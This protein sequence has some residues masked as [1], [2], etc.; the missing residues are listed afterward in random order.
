MFAANFLNL[1]KFTMPDVKNDLLRDLNS[2]IR[3]Y[4]IPDAQIITIPDMGE[5]EEEEEQ[6]EGK[7]D[8]EE[9]EGS[10][11]LDDESES[12]G[13][14]ISPEASRAKHISPSQRNISVKPI[15][16]RTTSSSRQPK[17]KLFVKSK[18]LFSQV[19]KQAS[20]Q[21][22]TADILG[23]PQQQQL[24]KRKISS[25]PKDKSPQLKKS[26]KEENF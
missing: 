4:P 23:I 5:E 20:Q 14:D 22:P 24:Q 10:E 13:L 12:K 9:H 3:R 1:E 19:Q 7:D 21:I 8:E 18:Q 17:A 15:Q 11:E 6:Q 25:Q 26:R 2:A 16:G